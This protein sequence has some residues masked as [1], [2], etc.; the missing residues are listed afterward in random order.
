[1]EFYIELIKKLKMKHMKHMKHIEK[2]KS[3]ILEVMGYFGR[4]FVGIR[5][6]NK[7]EIFKL[8]KNLKMK[9]REEFKEMDDEEFWECLPDTDIKKSIVINEDT[10]EFEFSFHVDDCSTYEERYNKHNDGTKSLG[11]ILFGTSVPLDPAE[12]KEELNP[13][14]LN[15]E[16]MIK[17]RDAIRKQFLS[18]A[19]ILLMDMHE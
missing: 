18:N 14:T 9:R 2:N 19:E 8:M 3:I 15:P 16:Y 12:K 6:S 1:M 13:E 11:G 7:K 5:V 4:I 17:V 10:R